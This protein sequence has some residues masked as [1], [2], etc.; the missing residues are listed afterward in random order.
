MQNNHRK[1]A[2]ILGG[3]TTGLGFARSL[4]EKGVT[5]TVME[6]SRWRPAMHSRWALPIIIPDAVTHPEKCVTRLLEWGKTQ[7]G[8]SV[9]IPTLEEYVQIL[10]DYREELKEFFL[11][12]V[13]PAS[14][15]NSI[16]DKRSQYHLMESCGLNIPRTVYSD[17]K[18]FIEAAVKKIGFPCIFKPCRSHIWRQIPGRFKARVVTSSRELETLWLS[19]SSLG[20]N[21]LVQEIIPGGDDCLHSYL[22][23][24]SAEGRP[25]GEVTAKKIRQHP[26]SYGTGCLI[27]S[28]DNP[29]LSAL[30]K[31][32][33]EKIGYVGHVDMEYKWDRRNQSYKF[34]EVNIRSTNFIQLTISSGIDLPWMGY[35]DAGY[36]EHSNPARQ[37]CGILFMHMGWDLQSVLTSGE[38]RISGFF[39]W[40]FQIRTVT[41]FA[42]F[43]FRDIKPIIW[44]LSDYIRK[45]PQWLGI[46]SR[47]RNRS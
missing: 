4:G 6:S 18:N 8:G 33:L 16:I 39:S 37:K 17:E 35:L 41:A 3:T 12:R 2:L 7:Q 45:L 19:L 25:L 44:E 27:I 42:V 23:C 26:V 14:L 5:V 22:A 24:Y 32:V 11:F 9:L 28:S 36:Q 30:S 31:G 46:N 40:L 10:S 43:N 15:V 1:E 34:I 47:K 20:L 38:N 29:E 13:P 21:F